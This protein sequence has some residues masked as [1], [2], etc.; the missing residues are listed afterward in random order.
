L[1]VR[2]RNT[3]DEIWSVEIGEFVS[4]PQIISNILY[5]WIKDKGLIAYDLSK[6]KIIWEKPQDRKDDEYEIIIEGGVMF[7]NSKRLMAASLKNGKVLWINNEFR[8]VDSFTLGMTKEYIFA[9][10]VVDDYTL[11]TASDK[12]TGKL[13][14]EGF[15]TIYDNLKEP[16]PD[17]PLANLEGKHFRFGDKMYKNFIYAVDVR[18]NIY[19]FE[20]KE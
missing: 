18:S 15:T 10:K 4:Y 20:V 6:R 2:N 5:V 16:K 17:R 3:G 9:Y 13:L 19:C 12:K 14:Y 8:S 11:L 1:Y 7:S